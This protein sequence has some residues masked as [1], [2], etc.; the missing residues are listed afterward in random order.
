M[1]KLSLVAVILLTCGFV[2][3]GF[4]LQASAQAKQKSTAI[5]FKYV[6]PSTDEPPPA[7]AVRGGIMRM[8]RPTFPKNLGYPP[9]WSPADSIFALPVAERL[10]DWDPKGNLIPWLAESWQSDPEKATITYRLRRG[11]KFQ[12]GTPFDAEAVKWNFQQRL[13]T[14]S[15]IEGDFIKSIDVLDEHTFRLNCSEI[16]TW[17][18][19]I[20]GFAQMLSPT[21]YEKNGGK[22]WARLNGVGTG[23]FKVVEFKRDTLL[24]YEKNKDYWR[25]GYPLLD[26]YEIRCVPDP[27]TASM[28]ME[29]KQA[30]IWMDASQTK[31]VLDLEQKGLKVN[32]GPGMFWALLPANGKD[33]KSPYANKKVREAVEYAIDRPAIAKSI[34]FGKFEPMPQ[35]VPS[36]SPAYIKGYDLRPYNPEKAKQLLAEAGYPNGFETK[37][38][39][40]DTQRNEA[41]AIQ[42]YLGAV[43]IKVS[44]DTADMGRYFAAVFSPAG[45]TDLVLAASGINPGGDDPLVHFGP[46]PWTYRFGFIAKSPEYLAD[47]EKAL[48]TFDPSGVKPAL[49]QT[50]RRASEDAMIIPLWR[51]AQAGVMQPWVHTD[52]PKIHIITWYS[53]QDWMEK[54]N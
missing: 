31:N 29:S 25:K 27:V 1:R 10:L 54:H 24:R 50:V 44:I 37:L 36:Y 28:M 5:V 17:S 22:E 32:W 14:K 35:I 34:G 38:M 7:N 21:A 47:C 49:Q 13:D 19:Y 15:L 2:L 48:K 51:S 30:D 53:H 52:Y 39:A 9:E 12:D 3:F 6:R 45:W 23:P 41:T 33:P 46:R 16:T 4:T 8:L 11:I 42:S 26:G 18:A 20:Y 40:M 43:G